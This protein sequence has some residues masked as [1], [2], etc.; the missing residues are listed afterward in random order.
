MET[1]ATGIA[2]VR[3]KKPAK[4]SYEK[5]KAKSGIP[6][7]TDHASGVPRRMER[8]EVNPPSMAPVRA[9]LQQ[10]RRASAGFCQHAS[11]PKAPAA[12]ATTLSANAVLSRSIFI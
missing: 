10:M 4:T 9:K 7:G 11:E 3:L 1:P 5:L 2:R 12:Y 6:D 8:T